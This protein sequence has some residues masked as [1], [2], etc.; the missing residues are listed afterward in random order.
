M[1]LPEK[2]KC[3]WREKKHCNSTGKIAILVRNYIAMQIKKFTFNPFQENS[4][5]LYDDT[6]ECIVIDPGC[7]TA[8]EEASI[9]SFIESQG[10]TVKRLINTHCHIDHILGNRYIADKY[11]VELESHELEVQILAG[12]PKWGEQYGIFCNPSPEITKFLAEG[13]K[14]KC[15]NFELDIL[16]CP[17]HSPGHIVLVNHATKDIIGGD[18]L[19]QGS[20]GR[21]D[22]P[23]GNIKD[24]HHSIVNKLF[25]LD[26]DYKVYAGHMGETTIGTEKQIN[27]ILQY[28]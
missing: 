8:T 5:I 17:G 14:V 26:P 16:H 11:G 1:V 24:L 23:G 28:A 12:S 19:F 21:V 18:V 13:D 22:L 3:S 10:L 15:G 6:K 27:P 9:S 4:Y 7:E 20:F 2:E 25:T